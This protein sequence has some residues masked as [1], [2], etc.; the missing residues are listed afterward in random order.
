[1]NDLTGKRFGRWTVISFSHRSKWR[2]PYWLCRC[3]CG[4]E[5]S[6][7]AAHLTKGLSQSCGCL[8]R[9]LAAKAQYKHGL[10]YH[11]LRQA[12]TQMKQRCHNPN[13][14]EYH[15]YGGRGITVCKRWRHSFANFLA[16][17]GERPEGMTLDR[18]DNDG[19]YSPDNCRWATEIQQHAN[20]RA[21]RYL[22]HD[23]MRLTV[24]QWARHLGMHPNTIRSRLRYGWSVADALTRP[25]DT[26]CHHHSQ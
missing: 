15:N 5:N 13:C 2:E 22:E 6:V 19:P 9:E 11:P 16:D 4:N 8:Q 7:R 21:N 14:D 20:M 25:I 23:G 17:M 1:M 26:R 3:E 24:A 12:Y 10:S 18:I